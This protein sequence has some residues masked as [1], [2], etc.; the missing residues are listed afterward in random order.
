MMKTQTLLPFALTSF[1][2]FQ[3]DV[4]GQTTLVLTPTQDAPVGK[5]TGYNSANTNYDASFHCSA[6]SQPGTNGGENVSRGLM[7]FDLS[8]I[9]SYA[10]IIGA[11]LTLSAT[12][13]TGTT[14]DVSPFGHVGQN[15]CELYRI[16]QS[17]QSSTVTW[18][19]QPTFTTSNAA[20]VAQSTW[21]LENYHNIDVTD[22]VQDMIV[23]GNY[24]FLLKLVNE[25]PTRGL[26][27]YGALAPH[28]EQRP[29]LLVIY[30]KCETVPQNRSSYSTTND[31]NNPPFEISTYPSI[32]ES[33]EEAVQLDLKGNTEGNVGL[34]L[35]NSLG[36][37]VYSTKSKNFPMSITLPP[38]MS[39][40]YVW[41][42]ETS[43]GN[44]LATTRMLVN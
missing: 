10:Q 35:I 2:C 12:G 33:S 41:I 29:T 24:G 19:T 34:S 6:I 23:Y 9:P 39:G 13:P 32:I 30:G 7:E 40:M 27:V 22:L 21:A 43:S 11:F 15:D 36:Q 26:Q 42:A 20:S 17:W 4:L 37:V 25:T 28:P 38:L 16:T 14:G 1:L 31:S 18:N 44:L 8:T 5:H 3:G